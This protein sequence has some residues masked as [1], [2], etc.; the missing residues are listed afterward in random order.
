LE[1]PGV[2]PPAVLPSEIQRIMLQGFMGNKEIAERLLAVEPAAWPT[3]PPPAAL[4][5][6]DALTRRGDLRSAARVYT[7]VLE[8]AGDQAAWVESARSGLGWIAVAQGDHDAIGR[9]F[10]LDD[11]RAPPHLGRVLLALTDA[12]DAK[13]GAPAVLEQ[14][15]QDAS[16]GP[17]LQDVAKLGVGYA[18]LW[19]GDYVRAQDAFRRFGGDLR[20]T[21]DA[22]YGAAWSRFQAGDEALARAAL[23]QLAERPA[24]GSRR[25]PSRALVELEPSAVLRA[26]VAGYRTLHVATDET[27]LSEMLDVDGPRLARA[28]LKLVDR[29]VASRPA[30]GGGEAQSPAHTDEPGVARAPA[31]RN[32]AGPQ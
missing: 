29:S 4:L 31:P 16:L 17:L 15:A 22:E 7:Q 13:P 27:W 24:T 32:P 11:G 8:Q 1:Q 14:L 6:A 20:F 5:L 2:A 30:A 26:G 12:A 18:H 25:R 28:A 9:Y 3:L 23:S 10:G 19:A 21:D